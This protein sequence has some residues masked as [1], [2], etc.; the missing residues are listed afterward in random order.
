M[1][2]PKPWG[3]DARVI[4]ALCLADCITITRDL[5]MSRIRLHC[6]AMRVGC[7]SEACTEDD[8]QENQ[9]PR[10]LEGEEAE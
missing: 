8:R 1:I 9:H 4:H 3:L 7:E 6:L 5:R 10:R 2:P